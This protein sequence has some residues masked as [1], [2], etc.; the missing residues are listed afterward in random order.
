MAIALLVCS[1]PFL[2]GAQTEPTS[3]TL[4]DMNYQLYPYS[5]RNHPRLP[6]P[7]KTKNGTETV[8][9]H[10]ENRN[11]HIIKVTLKSAPSTQWIWNQVEI[12]GR[13][14]PTLERTGRHSEQ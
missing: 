14:F 2:F 3:V 8:T 13:D 12:D 9:I 7:S 4:E 11:F 6:S 5:Y 1:I 10:L